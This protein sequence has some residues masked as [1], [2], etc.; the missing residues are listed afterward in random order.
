MRH[1][2]K[3]KSKASSSTGWKKNGVVRVMKL[4]FRENGE[5]DFE[6]LEVQAEVHLYSWKQGTGK[7]VTAGLH[8]GGWD[9]FGVFLSSLRN[10]QMKK[11]RRRRPGRKEL[12]T[13]L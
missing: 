8:V 13:G 11:G 3:K 4:H 2:K 10:E 1:G 6:M 12:P 5:F 9:S 7:R